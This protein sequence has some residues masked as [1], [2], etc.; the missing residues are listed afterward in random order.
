M[1]RSADVRLDFAGEERFFRLGIREMRVIQEK[2][3]AGPYEVFLRL[4]D[5]RWRVDDVRETILQGLIGGGME[6]VPALKLVEKHFDALP[7][8]QFIPVAMGVLIAALSGVEDEPVGEP[9]AGTVKKKSRSR[10]TKS[11]LATSTKSEAQ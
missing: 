10:A 2:V 7:I 8:L 6:T 9:E 1:S 4:Q 5:S 11:A 3:D